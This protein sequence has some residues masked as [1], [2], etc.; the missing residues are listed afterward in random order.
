MTGW[1][2]STFR[3]LS[4]S[5][6]GAALAISASAALTPTAALAQNE[7][8]PAGAEEES[9]GR[10]LD[11]YIAWGCLSGLALFVIAKSARRS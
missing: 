10:T 4:P 8:P 6:L 11:G 3:F 7:P 5:V 2:R 9:K 1:C